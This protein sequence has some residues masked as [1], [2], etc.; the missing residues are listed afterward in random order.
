MGLLTAG[1]VHVSE[2]DEKSLSVAVPDRWGEAGQTGAPDGWLADFGDPQLEKLVGEAL[3]E[4]LQLQ[5]AVA[6]LDQAMA[7]ARIEGADRWPTLSLSGNAQRQMTNSL[8]DPP[9]RTRSDR[10]G[11]DVV[12]SWELDLWGRIRAG[13][14]AAGAEA[15]AAASDFRGVQLSL[16]S[17][18]AQA[19]F[20]AIEARQQESLA[21]ETVT[22]F[23]SNLA[24]VEER[25]E[26]GLS[27]ALDLRLTRANVAS[28]RSTLAVQERLA[29]TAVRQLEVLLGR[30]PAGEAEVSGSLPGLE[31]GI[32]AGL[33]SEL[34]ARRPDIQ[35]SA[36]RL[37]ASD[38]RLQESERALLPS[39]NLT[40]SYG[41]ASRDLDNLLE[42]SF[43]VWSLVGGL[44]APLFQG[45]RL[46]ANVDRSEAAL[47]EALASYR[48]TALT[49]FRE[50]ETAL[51]GEV[52]LRS[53][54]EALEIAAE[55][56]TGAQ[57]LAEERYARGLVNIITVL[58]SQRRAFNSRSAVLAAENLL[59]QNRLSLY[60]SLGGD[61]R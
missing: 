42:N 37:M 51:A 52:Y 23:E 59:L 14:E 33:P 32:P 17:R 55:E 18:V 9:L 46:R 21:R 1:C 3:A 6:R 11:L 19:W 5:A 2:P 12:A 7:L 8:S 10:F 16:A 27:P 28:A 26:R 13:S 43:D 48:D 15:L 25:F 44:T 41:R 34:L 29:D 56:S 58:E 20:S 57:E 22:S 36:R 24:T 31:E 38:A 30:Y 40:G 45:G 50:V 49:A 47:A 4:N 54:L 39:I 53:Q 61:L 60:L 35:A